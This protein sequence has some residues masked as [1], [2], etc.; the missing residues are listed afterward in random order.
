MGVMLLV[1]GTVKRWL[2]GRGYGFIG[3][4]GQENDVF[5]HNT[6]VE[7]R[8]SL[9]IGERVEFDIEDTDR[10]PRAVNVQPVTE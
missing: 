3:V 9:R 6:N 1:K 8:S 2:D 4:D 7:G 10:G 5:V